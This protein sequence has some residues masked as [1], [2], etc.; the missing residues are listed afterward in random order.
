MGRGVP[1]EPPSDHFRPKRAETCMIVK[2]FT[3]TFF[4]PFGAK[5]LLR[6][7]DFNGQ[8]AEPVMELGIGARGTEVG[9]IG[10]CGLVSVTTG[11]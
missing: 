11:Y 7:R 8:D 10:Y 1:A 6:E 9:C 2:I 5:F 3:S 4:A